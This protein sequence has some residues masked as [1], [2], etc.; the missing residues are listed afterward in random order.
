[1]ASI[2][3]FR[4]SPWEQGIDE[5]IAYRVTTTPW[6]GG[7]SSPAVTVTL[8]GEDVTDAVT[9][10]NA[11][12]DGDT[13]TTPVIQGLTAGNTYRLEV[14]WTTTDGRVLEAYGYIKATE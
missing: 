2:R 12:G 10:G 13:I 5:Q 3:E 6:G 14:R 7:S 4:E 9:E 8:N 11:S 1:M